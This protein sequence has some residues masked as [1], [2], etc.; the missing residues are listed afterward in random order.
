[1]IFWNYLPSAVRAEMEQH[2]EKSMGT[3]NRWSTSARTSRDS[4]ADFRE[5]MIFVELLSNKK[6]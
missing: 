3:P 6:T 5:F 4:V 2:F 1:M